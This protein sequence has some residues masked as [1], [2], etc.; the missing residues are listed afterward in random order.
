[1]VATLLVTAM[2]RCQLLAEQLL[3]ESGFECK[4]ALEYL[5]LQV[6]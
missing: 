2:F 3:A 1:M 4:P 5:T 6:I